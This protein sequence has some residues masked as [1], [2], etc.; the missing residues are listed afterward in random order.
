MMTI[1]NNT[2]LLRERRALETVV[3]REFGIYLDRE[4]HRQTQT[5]LMEKP[6]YD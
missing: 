1:N 5:T 4:R 3:E 2:L 6:S